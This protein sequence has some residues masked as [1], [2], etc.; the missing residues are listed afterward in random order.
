MTE[1][2]NVES[3]DPPRSRR[4]DQDGDI[5]DVQGWLH[6]P[7]TW[8]HER[9]LERLWNRKHA[10]RLGVGFSIAGNPRR[11]FMIRDVRQDLDWIRSELEALVAEIEQTSTAE[12]GTATVGSMGEAPDEEPTRMEGRA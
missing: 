9:D 2:I 8:N 1:P 7:V 6:A 3:I 12:V 4:H 11:H 5:V 10:S